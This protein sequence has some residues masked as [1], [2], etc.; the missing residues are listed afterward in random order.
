MVFVVVLGEN[1]MEEIFTVKNVQDSFQKINKN[2]SQKN[3]EDLD[4]LAVTVW[5][6]IK[7]EFM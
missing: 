6:E 3:L 4:V 2:V 1:E 5:S 7:N